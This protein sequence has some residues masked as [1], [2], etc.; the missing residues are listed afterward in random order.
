MNKS[1]ILTIIIAV[2]GL[3][4]YSQEISQ[5]GFNSGSGEATSVFGENI[6]FT[7]GQAYV[8][9]TLTENNADYVTQGFEQPSFKG[10]EALLSPA[11]PNLELVKMDVFPNPAV[12]YTDLVLN[13][14]DDNGAKVALVDMWGQ[15]VKSQ[16]F[17]VSQGQQ[18]LHFSFGYLAAGVYTVKVSAN[19]RVYAKKLL[20]SGTGSANAL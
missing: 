5:Q 8:T 1:I 13:L 19:T 16:D 15:V 14:I 7:I 18:K 4:S 17:N 2:L 9:N 20:V 3:T 12:D 11:F 6:Q 10:I